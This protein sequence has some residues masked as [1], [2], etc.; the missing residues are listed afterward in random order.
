MHKKFEINRTKIKVGCQ[1]NTVSDFEPKIIIYNWSLDPNNGKIFDHPGGIWYSSVLY[2]TGFWK[3]RAK[4]K[5]LPWKNSF[6]IS[7][8]RTKIDFGILLYYLVVFYLAGKL[9]K[10]WEQFFHVIEIRKSESREDFAVSM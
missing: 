10:L 2:N 9:R 5:L 6:G 3:E 8:V 7:G 1:S 4:V